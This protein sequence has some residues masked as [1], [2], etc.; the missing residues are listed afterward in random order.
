MTWPHVRASP[1]PLVGISGCVVGPNHQPPQ[2]P[3]PSVA[4]LRGTSGPRSTCPG[5]TPSRFPGASSLL[6]H[7]VVYP[8]PFYTDLTRSMCTTPLV[9]GAPGVA[10]HWSTSVAWKRRVEGMV[11]PRAWAVFRLITSA[12]VVGCSTGRSAGLAPLRSLPTEAAVRRSC[13]ARLTP[14]AVRPPVCKSFRPAGGDAGGS[15]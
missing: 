13:S 9:V 2:I 11:I 7:Q 5:Q 15:R 4:S 8:Q 14:D 10:D 1:S 6:V 3:V 12:N